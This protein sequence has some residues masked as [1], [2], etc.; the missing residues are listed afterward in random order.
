MARA[1]QLLRGMRTV[2]QPN[3]LSRWTAPRVFAAAAL[4]ALL[5]STVTWAFVH[6]PHGRTAPVV[7]PYPVRAAGPV[8]ADGSVA[9]TRAL[10][11]SNAIRVYY[12]AVHGARHLWNRDNRRARTDYHTISGWYRFMEAL[13]Q[14]GYEIHSERYASFDRAT[15]EPY[16]VFVIGEQ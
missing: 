16:D 10:A 13:R 5:G 12:D 4:G 2:A 3:E 7:L 11:P 15:L 6:A 14:A 9:P 8:V 1:M